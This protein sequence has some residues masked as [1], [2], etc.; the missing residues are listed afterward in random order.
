V[1]VVKLPSM[2]SFLVA[3][4]A[5]SLTTAFC[6]DNIQVHFSPDGGCT[7]AVVGQLANLIRT[8]W[9][10]SGANALMVEVLQA[11]GLNRSSTG[12]SRATNARGSV[13]RT[14]F[15]GFVPGSL[16]EACWT[17][18]LAK[19]NSKVQQLWG[20]YILPSGWP[21]N[22]VDLP[23]L[24]WSKDCV[25]HGVTGQTAISQCNTMQGARGQLPMTALTPRHL[26]TRGHGF[27]TN[28]VGPLLGVKIY[29]CTTSNTVVEAVT[30]NK[31]T[32]AGGYGFGADGTNL[33][34]TI[35]GLMA[36]LPDSI[37]PLRVINYTNKDRR[38]PK[39]GVSPI[40]RLSTRQGGKVDCG[41][42]S[43]LETDVAGGDSG[44]PAF[45]WIGNEIFLYGG[46]SSELA[47]IPTAQFAVDAISTALGLN[48]NSYQL[49]Y[50]DI[51]SY[52]TY[53]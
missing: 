5:L 30:T 14:N 39:D 1:T 41:W 20:T 23:T 12:V 17:N 52:P 36:D 49:R 19:T 50:L 11:D 47:P 29:F 48:T 37:T 31:F 3:L 27:G 9:K 6:A 8:A 16:P 4:L 22:Y 25:I 33:D 38:F 2:K 43:G 15:T 42:K 53:P 10:A 45:L 7:A 18:Y 35:V 34:F 40:P 21:T 28:G 26:L 46:I 32:Y 24:A 44:S 13:S 51:S